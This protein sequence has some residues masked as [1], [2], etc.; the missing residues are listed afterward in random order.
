M[1][2]ETLCKD[3]ATTHQV[4]ELQFKLL[5]HLPK[6]IHNV[7]VT[8]K[9]LTYLKDVDLITADGVLKEDQPMLSQIRL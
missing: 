6:L 5:L 2:A 3:Q 4:E 1:I 9:M 8:L 7:S